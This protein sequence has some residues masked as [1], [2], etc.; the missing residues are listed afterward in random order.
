MTIDYNLHAREYARNR[1]LHPDVLAS[2]IEETPITA[3]S[4]VLEVGC[5]SGNYI[6]AIQSTTGCSCWGIDPSEKMLA[7][8]QT[9]ASV[10][11]FAPGRA[12]QLEFPD[13]SF[14]LLFS[15]DVIHH[16]SDLPAYFHEAFRVLK[17]GGALCTVTDSEEIIRHRQPLSVYFP[18]TIE[19]ELRRYPRVETLIELMCQAGFTSLRQTTVEM[20]YELTDMQPY[21][22]RAFSSLHFISP[23]AYQSGIE[24]MRFDL[25]QAPIQANARYVLLWGKKP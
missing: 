8:A 10:V 11:C 23:N 21:L 18:E 13:T 25:A 5:G 24:R 6:R 12:E 9:A 20:Q 22:D 4:S 3:Q 7:E 1:K 2:L 16:I 14:D 15:V 17:P 19:V